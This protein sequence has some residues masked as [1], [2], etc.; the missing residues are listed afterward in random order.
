MMMQ[1]QQDL[2]GKAPR[3]ACFDGG[4]ASR[5][6][7]AEIK[8]LGVEDVVFHK[9]CRLEIEDMTKSPAVYRMLRAF[10]AGIEGVIS[11]LKRGFGLDRCAWRG[12]ESFKA[13]VQ[14]SVLACNLLTI[15]RHALAAAKTT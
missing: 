9:R 14:A 4:F 7:L 2:Y 8:A 3:Q 11:F 12:F 13:Y 6:N 15:A 10:R 1:R 5:A